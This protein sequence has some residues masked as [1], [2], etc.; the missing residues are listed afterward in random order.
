MRGR[1][2]VLEGIDG[3]GKSTLAQAL[4]RALDKNGERPWVTREETDTPRGAWVRQSIAEG[5]DPLATTFLFLADRAE[6]AR[7]IE[8]RLSAGQSVLCDRYMHSTL[9]YQHVTLSGRLLDVDDF[10]LR[11]HEGLP[12]PD[13]VLL[14]DLDPERAMARLGDRTGRARYEKAAFLREVRAQY[15]ALAAKDAS[16]VVVDADRPADAVLSDCL[17]HLGLT[18]SH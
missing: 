1:F 8:E 4:G 11:L 6:H 12:R 13:R 10:L 2:I 5:W 16:M 18:P 17:G 15:L 14:L 9:A 3:S 7:R